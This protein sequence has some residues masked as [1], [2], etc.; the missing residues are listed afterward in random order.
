MILSLLLS[1]A[2]ACTQLPMRSPTEARLNSVRLTKDVPLKLCLTLPQPPRSSLIEFKTVNK[3]NS[4]CSDLKMVMKSPDK[5][6]LK[7][8]GSQPGIATFYQPGTWN[9]KYTL[10]EGC[11]LYDLIAV[12]SLP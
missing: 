10:K 2:Q 6:K 9:L 7:S 1:V 3:G 12:W 8:H 4:S 5:T 11:D